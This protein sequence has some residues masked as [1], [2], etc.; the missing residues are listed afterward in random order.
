MLTAM[1]LI[2]TGLNFDFNKVNETV[3]QGRPQNADVF[4]IAA[5]I[6]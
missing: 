6:R 4:W 5:L 1:Y 2:M 3:K